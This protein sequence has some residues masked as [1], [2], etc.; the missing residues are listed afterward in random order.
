MPLNSLQDLYVEELRDLYNAEQQ[1]VKALPKMA[2]AAYSPELKDAFN[3]HLATTRLQ[4]ER[5]DRIFKDL[6]KTP[7]GKKCLGMQGVIE[8]GYDQ[9]P[10]RAVRGGWRGRI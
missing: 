4:V 7:R 6:H 10:G 5:L 1:I 3:E 2:K 8:E 9:H